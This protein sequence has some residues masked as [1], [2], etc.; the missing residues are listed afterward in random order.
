MN[1]S[2]KEAKLQN[3][4][5][6]KSN[7]ETTRNNASNDLTIVRD[8]ISQLEDFSKKIS[9]SHSDLDEIKPKFDKIGSYLEHV[10]LQGKPFDEGEFSKKGQNISSSSSYLLSLLIS[11]NDEI[12]RL[13][14]Q[15]SSLIGTINNCN[16]EINALN[17]Q[18]ELL[19]NS[20]L[21]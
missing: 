19:S 1:S 20:A 14:T 9:K 7:Y 3:L 17:T 6:N 11:V 13:K 21:G 12:S 15:E 10:I 16:T 18:I 2:D 5:K 4:I 8:K